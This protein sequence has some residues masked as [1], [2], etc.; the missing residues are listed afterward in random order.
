MPLM[1]GNS[2]SPKVA[3]YNKSHIPLDLDSS[4]YCVESVSLILL[5]KCNNY[6]FL[7]EYT[8]RRISICFRSLYF[9]IA[10]LTFVNLVPNAIHCFPFSC[11][12]IPTVITAVVMV[13]S[14]TTLQIFKRTI[15]G[16]IQRPRR[17]ALFLTCPTLICPPTSLPRCVA[18]VYLLDSWITKLH[19]FTL[20]SL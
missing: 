13:Q 3:R 15:Q 14:Y 2:P 16:K 9:L 7:P 19:K 6:T 10:W 5:W 12:L 8:R 1:I 20:S 11:S 17:I 18:E 4:S